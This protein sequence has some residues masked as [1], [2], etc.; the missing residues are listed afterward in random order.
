MVPNLFT[1]KLPALVAVPAAVVT[2]IVP[3]A[4]AAGVAVICVA[5]FTINDKALVPPKFTAVAPVK[6][7][8]VITTG[9]VLSQPAPG[10]KLVIDGTTTAGI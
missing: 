6:L 1:V 4:P 8:P 10:V 3:V 2:L 7:V 5:E 9:V